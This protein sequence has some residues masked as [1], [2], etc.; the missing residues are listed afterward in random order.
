MLPPLDPRKLNA[1]IHD[2]EDEDD[3]THDEYDPFN[4]IC[5]AKHQIKEDEDI[6]M[7]VLSLLNLYPCSSPEMYRDQ[8]PMRGDKLRDDWHVVFNVCSYLPLIPIV[9]T[10]H[11]CGH[12]HFAVSASAPA[13]AVLSISLPSTNLSNHFNS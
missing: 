1:L 11:A 13:L 5:S 8:I 2:D 7:G 9:I 6:S 4:H 12:P 3:L 10:D